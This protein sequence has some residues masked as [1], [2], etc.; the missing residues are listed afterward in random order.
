MQADRNLNRAPLED[1]LGDTLAAVAD[2]GDEDLKLVQ[3]F[4]DALATLAAFRARSGA[5]QRAEKPPQVH[6][7]SSH[8]GHHLDGRGITPHRS[9]HLHVANSPV[10]MMG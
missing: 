1:A 9:D 6:R 4:V 2:L 10:T 5:N 7:W 8:G 3:N